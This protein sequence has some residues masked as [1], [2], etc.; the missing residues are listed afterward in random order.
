MS[1]SRDDQRPLACD[2]SALDPTERAKRSALARE[3]YRM[4]VGIE[5]LPDGYAFRYPA[6]SSILMKIAQFVSIERLCCPFF[7]FTIEVEPANTSMSLRLT[8]GDGV[9]RFIAG[10]LGIEA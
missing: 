6:D 5:D 3:L 1:T 4:R 9:K 7:T 2:L 8:G 10:E